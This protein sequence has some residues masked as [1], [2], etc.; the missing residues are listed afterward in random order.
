MLRIIGEPELPATS[1]TFCYQCRCQL[2]RSPRDQQSVCSFLRS[3]WAAL[4]QMR[5]SLIPDRTGDA[6]LRIADTCAL[7]LPPHL[8]H[9]LLENGRPCFW[10][11]VPRRDRTSTRRNSSH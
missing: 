5:C 6:A 7:R 11:I 1:S 2:Q 3:S 8:H 9:L 4:L 10:V